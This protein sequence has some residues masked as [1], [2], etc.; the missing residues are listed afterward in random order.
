MKDLEVGL[1]EAK[2]LVGAGSRVYVFISNLGELELVGEVLGAKDRTY[3][4]DIGIA[5]EIIFNQDIKAIR[6]VGEQFKDAVIVCPHGNTSLRFAEALSKL[7]VQSYSLNGGIEKL[8]G[9]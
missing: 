5:R 3:G 7:G 6:K 1:E 4:M 2:G 8:R 9:R